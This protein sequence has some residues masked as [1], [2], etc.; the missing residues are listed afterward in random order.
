MWRFAAN[1]L[2]PAAGGALREA[3]MCHSKAVRLSRIRVGTQHCLELAIVEHPIGLGGVGIEPSDQCRALGR[4]Q[5]CSDRAAV[6]LSRSGT[7]I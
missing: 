4:R 3:L 7:D 2:P 5:S 6:L 1:N